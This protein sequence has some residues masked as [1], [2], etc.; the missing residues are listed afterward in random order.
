MRRDE[1]GV[2]VELEHLTSWAGRLLTLNQPHR[3]LCSTVQSL[4]AQHRVLPRFLLPIELSC[5]LPARRAPLHSSA[6][7]RLLPDPTTR[8]ASCE[9]WR[10]RTLCARGA[11]PHF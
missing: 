10:G 3:A 5:S 8:S 4:S 11:Y 6:R 2:P 9:T 7:Y 1:R